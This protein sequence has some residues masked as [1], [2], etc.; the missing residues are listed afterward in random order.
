MKTDHL[1]ILSL[2][3]A[4]VT[5]MDAFPETRGSESYR[6][7]HAG[8]RQPILLSETGMSFGECVGIHPLLTFIL[9]V[10][11][12]PN[13]VTVYSA[14]PHS[15]ISWISGSFHVSPNRLMRSVNPARNLCIYN[16]IEMG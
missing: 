3:T 12:N 15:A 5:Y 2:S 11:E 13:V 9:I 16:V 4:L 6:V 7:E 1:P 8:M 10:R 14:R